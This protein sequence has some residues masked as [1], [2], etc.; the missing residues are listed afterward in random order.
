MPTAQ[1]PSYAIDPTWYEQQKVSLEAA[2]HARRCISCQAASNK[3]DTTPASRSSRAPAKG[4]TPAL[5]G[6]QLEMRA[7]SEDC[8]QKQDYVTADTPLI[9]AVFRTLLAN[10]NR[11]T[12]FQHL[13]EQI[14]Q[15]YAVGEM[16]KDVAPSTLERVLARQRTY[17]IKQ[18]ESSE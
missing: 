9:E 12:A 8:A 11:P 14:N 13:V 10:E 15:R 2:V 17:G 3:K 18:V 16:P 5:S 4:K 6:W 7:L 1:G